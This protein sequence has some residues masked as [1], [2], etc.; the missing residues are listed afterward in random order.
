MSSDE[1][2]SLLAIVAAL[3]FREIR[4]H[5]RTA[6]RTV[7]SFGV[8]YDFESFQLTEA[9]PMPPALQ[10][11]R[12]RCADLAGVAETSL[13]EALVT[14]YPPGSVMGW[15][16]DAPV[17]GPTVVG[18]SLGSAC[19]MRFRRGTA[20]KRRVYEVE[21]VPRSAYVLSGAAR[22]SWQHSIPPV[23][24]LR[25]SVTFRQLRRA[26]GWQWI[27]WARTPYPGRPAACRLTVA[28]SSP[29]RHPG[30]A[31]RLTSG[32]RSTCRRVLP[33]HGAVHEAGPT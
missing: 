31:V 27:T 25:Y 20:E 11:A 3:D 23:P 1:E 29:S 21:L 18:L 24:Q 7:R 12:R 5:G 2:R 6:R 14:R 26:A 15:H 17:F 10:Q 8:D 19:L 30:P 9:E 16:R 32:V 4:M 22:S 13:A 28:A 33:A